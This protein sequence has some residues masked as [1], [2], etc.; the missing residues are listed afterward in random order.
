MKT[1]RK[2]ILP[3]IFILAAIAAFLMR[4]IVQ[5]W[6][7][8]PAAKAAWL[9]NGYYKAIPQDVFW[10]S[11]LVISIIMF[12]IVLDIKNDGNRPVKKHVHLPGPVTEM[13]F[14]IQRMKK[15]VYPRWHMAQHLA[16]LALDINDWRGGKESTRPREMD[17][18]LRIPSNI[19]LYLDTALRNN[20]ARFK[21]KYP[22]SR[23]RTTPLDQDIEP[24]LDYLESALE[25]DQNDNY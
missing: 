6:I 25:V 16:N 4:E 17:A 2:I 10:V 1:S 7:L 24:I 14:W 19:R 21:E 13:T 8:V 15:G 11:A 3:V 12:L 9:V 5:R 20:F 18:G 23:T 22:H